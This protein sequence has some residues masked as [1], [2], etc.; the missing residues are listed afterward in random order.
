MFAH[1]YSLATDTFCASASSTLGHQS[2]IVIA[3]EPGLLVI[4]PGYLTHFVHPY[5]GATPRISIAF[6][7]RVQRRG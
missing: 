5:A 2:R 4:F 7:T 1:S 6:N 3:P